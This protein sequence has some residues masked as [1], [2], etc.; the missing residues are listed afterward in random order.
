MSDRTYYFVFPEVTWKETGRYRKRKSVINNVTSI[1]TV[2]PI[3]LCY[4]ADYIFYLD[5]KTPVFM[6][7][8][9][10]ENLSEEDITTIVL[11][12]KD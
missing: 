4:Q 11:S 12:A 1:P 7:N 5:G 3:R 10:L 8:R 9:R 6:K 2:F